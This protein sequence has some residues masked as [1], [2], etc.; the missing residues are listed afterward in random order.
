[1]VVLTEGHSDPITAKTACSLIRYCPDEVVAVFDRQAAGRTS[2]GLLGLGGDIPVIGK[3]ADAKAPDTLVI[4]IAPS[5][6]RI[7][8][9]W[10]PIL[11]QAIER[12]LN[13]V[14]GLHQ[15]LSD[16]PEFAAAAKGANVQLIDVRRNAENDVA[17]REGIREDCL[18]VQTVGNDCCVGKMLTSID[19]ARG[20]SKIGQDARFVAT[21]Q[22]GIMIA[23]D[24]CPIDCVVSDFVNGAAENLVRS[25]QHH[26][27]LVIEGQGTLSHPRYSAV[28][29]GLLHGCMPHGLIMCYEAGRTRLHHMESMPIISFREL[30]AAYE[31]MA[32]LMHPCRIIGIAMNSRLL[33]DEKAT[34]ERQRMRD[35]FELPVCDVVRHGPQDLVDAV[36]R[37]QAEMRP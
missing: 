6:G 8:P 33:S 29:L 18:R 2:Q 3:L 5:G 16:D 12:R 36:L 24:G 10:R 13:I 25:N 27:I 7:P 1:M 30:I 32:N 11:L 14:S 34:E 31:T 22:T 20:L 21:G 19:V 35:E 17:S 26:D 9:D 37:L 28:T 23:G 15:F 4:G